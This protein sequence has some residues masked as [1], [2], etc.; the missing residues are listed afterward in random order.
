MSESY[1]MQK[2]LWA[3]ANGIVL[4]ALEHIDSVCGERPGLPNSPI[5]S[6]SHV[7]YYLALLSNGLHRVTGASTII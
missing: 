6:G 5:V 3:A 2:R 7:L 4:K 1:V